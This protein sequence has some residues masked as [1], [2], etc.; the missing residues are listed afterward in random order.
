MTLYSHARNEFST[1]FRD[2]P[3]ILGSIMEVVDNV[4]GNITEPV[5]KK[6]ETPQALLNAMSKA[7]GIKMTREKG[8]SERP[9]LQATA[10]Q[11]FCYQCKLLFKRKYSLDEIGDIIGGG[12]HHTSVLHSIETC[13]DRLETRDSVMVDLHEKWI[14]YNSGK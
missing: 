2:R 5:T 6:Y 11:Y 8:Q 10:I 14:K 13:K 4:F 9:R 3:N 12:Y 7:F 1:V